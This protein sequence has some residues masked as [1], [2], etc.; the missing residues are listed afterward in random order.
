[1]VVNCGNVKDREG[2]YV[3]NVVHKEL[4]LRW[5]RVKRQ[6]TVMHV[7]SHVIDQVKSHVIDQVFNALEALP[8]S[9]YFSAELHFDLQSLYDNSV[10]LRLSTDLIDSHTHH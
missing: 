3:K 4:L 5:L 1:M 10:K 9:L 2:A 6:C 7:K 8:Y